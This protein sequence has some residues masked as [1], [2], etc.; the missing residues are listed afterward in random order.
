MKNAFKTTLSALAIV[1]VSAVS[2]AAA[3]TLSGTF[4]VQV[5]NKTGLNSAQSEATR[6]NF[7]T[8]FNA[9]TDN[10]TKDTFTYT[11][12][13]D[14]ATF[15]ANTT[16]I[17]QWLASNVPGTED[18]NATV[19]GKQL[20][21]A[22]INNGSATSTFFLFTLASLGATNFSIDHDD[23]IAVFD[24]GVRIGGNNGPTS[25][26]TTAVNGFNGG[27]FELLY[28]ATN[29]NPSVLKVNATAVPVPAAGFLLLGALGGLAALRR[30][31]AA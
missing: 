19:G 10:V 6:A 12:A 17:A 7:D 20:S 2:A 18:I 3:T 1:A 23:G 14:F 22:D 9:A 11:G 26:V 16:T 21:K 4:T 13:L 30:R 15:G 28:V 24:D 8:Y 25:Q 27:K 29:G 5:V 31:K